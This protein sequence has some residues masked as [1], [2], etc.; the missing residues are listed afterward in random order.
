MKRST[1]IGFALLFVLGLSGFVA[2]SDAADKYPAKPIIFLV[3][4]EAGSSADMAARALAEKLQAQL[5]QPVV[6]TNKPGAGSTIGNRELHNAKPDGYTIGMSTATIFMNRLQG[7]LPYDHN[8]YTVLGS[9][10]NWAPAVVASTKTKRPFNTMQE[11]IAAAK[12][13]PGDVILST[14]SVG[15]VW[16]VAAMDF[17]KKTGLQFNVVPQTS[18]SGVV[19]LQVAG[20]HADIGIT[21][22]TA[23]KSQIDAGNMK[24]LALL[25]A[26]RLPNYPSVPTMKELGY[27]T[28]TLSTHLALAPPKLPGEIRTIL[29]KAFEKAANDPEY[30]DFLVKN[31]GIPS[32]ATPEET[33]KWMNSQRDVY[34]EIMRSAG[35]LKEK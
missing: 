3:P 1:L 20:G 2:K 9:Y 30:K 33:I 23:S 16:W 21:D 6:V 15:Q 28:V 26:N 14:G 24:V 31:N 4:N 13:K 18:S 5:G 25:G 7:L 17:I 10:L 35:I 27:D 22:V 8:D 29:L 34:R 12:A 11:V 32:Y 19:V